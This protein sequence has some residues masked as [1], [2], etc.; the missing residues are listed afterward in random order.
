MKEPLLTLLCFI[1][2]SKILL[3]SLHD[4]NVTL[5]EGA[6]DRFLSMICWFRLK[7]PCPLS[8]TPLKNSSPMVDLLAINLARLSMVISEE[9]SFLGSYGMFLKIRVDLRLR[10]VCSARSTCS[11]SSCCRISLLLLSFDVLILSAAS[12]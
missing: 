9:V 7:L 10:S 5:I 8:T 1:I 4:R 6:F 12:I 2:V 11:F 3:D